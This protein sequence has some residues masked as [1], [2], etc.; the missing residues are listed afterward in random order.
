MGAFHQFYEKINETQQARLKDDY[1]YIVLHAV[2]E[3]VDPNFVGDVE[4]S[5][6]EQKPQEEDSDDMVE[7]LFVSDDFEE[8]NNA[9][10]AVSLKAE[11]QEEEIAA[12]S[13]NDVSRETVMKDDSKK[14]RKDRVINLVKGIDEK[15][16]EETFFIQDLPD[17]ED[18]AITL[19]VCE[20]QFEKKPINQSEVLATETVINT[21]TADQRQTR[22][23]RLIKTPAA[24]S[25]AKATK[26]G[27]KRKNAEPMDEPAESNSSTAIDNAA[28]DGENDQ[29]EAS[30]SKRKPRKRATKMHDVPSHIILDEGESDNEFP[31]RDSDNDDWPAPE[32]VSVFPKVMIRN[33]VLAIKGRGLM[34]LINK[35]EQWKL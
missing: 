11:P 6:V 12:V 7:L 24:P 3:R 9:G 32:T 1:K 34:D 20:N 30:S 13:T 26:S 17:D 5:Y 23:G 18:E 27:R 15:T 28:N 35:Y 22:S 29:L 25:E 16:G 4:S 14:P 8:P 21:P 2:Y 10:E 31:A 19:S 33:G